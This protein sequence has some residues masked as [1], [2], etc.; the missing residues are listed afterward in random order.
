MIGWYAMSNP[1]NVIR[2]AG[3]TATARVT[4]PWCGVLTSGDAK[5]VHAAHRTSSGPFEY[6][7]VYKC[8]DPGCGRASLL[9][10]E[11]AST[12]VSSNVDLPATIFPTRRSSYAPDG[13]PKNIAQDFREAQD[14]YSSGFRYGAAVVARRV[15]QAAVRSFTGELKDL[16]TEINTLTS[17]QLPKPLR[18]A[19]HEVRFV[20]N[21]AAHA[22]QVTDDEVRDLLEFT[23]QALHQLFTVPAKVTAAAA[24]RAL[25]P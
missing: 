18:D 11:T 19:A 3:A 20:G 23:E 14:S 9:V 15:L 7:V 17:D 12:A 25:K 16:K 22:D 4:C 8:A 13:V 2:V 5:S 10:F 6:V 24:R 1:A 21:D